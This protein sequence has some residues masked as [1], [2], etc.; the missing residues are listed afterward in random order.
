[1]QQLTLF[2][3][4]TARSLTR[5]PGRRRKNARAAR[6]AGTRWDLM[7]AGN[8]SGKRDGIVFPGHPEFHAAY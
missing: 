8:G 2:S 1:M 5:R 6:I 4:N 7:V 3:K